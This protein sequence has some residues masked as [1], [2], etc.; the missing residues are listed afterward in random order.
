[1]IW[2]SSLGS[3]NRTIYLP[4]YSDQLQ[5][6]L[7]IKIQLFFSGRQSANSIRLE[8]SLNV[9]GAIPP[10]DLSPSMATSG[11]ALFNLNHLPMY[12]ALKR[13]HPFWSYKGTFH[14]VLA[15]YMHIAWSIYFIC[16]A[17]ITWTLWRDW[18]TNPCYIPFCVLLLLTQC[19][20]Q[21]LLITF[22][23]QSLKTRYSF[24]LTGHILHPHKMKGIFD[25]W[26]MKHST[27]SGTSLQVSHKIQISFL[28]TA[29]HPFPSQ[30]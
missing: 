26:W 6:P 20:S 23:S 2:D 28:K 21:I 19:M 11:S 12:K 1:M 15:A 9:S 13:P 7:N 29:Q 18:I 10:L 24:N 5:H 8:P 17:P 25:F 14:T 22:L 27:A 30:F 3:S 16:I 4:K